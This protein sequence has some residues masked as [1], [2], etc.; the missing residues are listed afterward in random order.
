MFCAIGLAAVPRKIVEE[1]TCQADF[2]NDCSRTEKRRKVFGKE[3]CFICDLIIEKCKQTLAK[4]KSKSLTPRVRY[5]MG[6][7]RFSLATSASVSNLF[8]VF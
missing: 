5:C 1:C 6:S 3:E 7:S 4:K 2:E 8:I